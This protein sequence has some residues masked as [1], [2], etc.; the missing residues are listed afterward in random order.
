MINYI[1]KGIART[2]NIS[3]SDVEAGKYGPLLKFTKYIGAGFSSSSR[4]IIRLLEINANSIRTSEIYITTG[5]NYNTPSAP[6][7]NCINLIPSEVGY[8]LNEFE[9]HYIL[10]VRPSKLGGYIS[11]Q[12]LFCENI[13]FIESYNFEPFIVEHDSLDNVVE[14]VN[15]YFTLTPSGPRGIKKTGTS[16]GYYKIATLFARWNTL[17]CTYAFSIC[18]TQN[19]DIGSFIGGTVYIKAR[20]TNDDYLTVTIKTGG[21]TENFTNDKINIIAVPVS[22]DK[23]EIYIHSLKD[24]NA[25]QIKDDFWEYDNNATYV[26]VFE[27]IFYETISTDN[28]TTLF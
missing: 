11:A 9:D 27:P 26:R 14:P 28:Q 1:P 6:I 12:V 24:W 7:V 4:F 17:G 13:S 22:S 16:K 2:K 18:N 3:A 15:G 5:E 23:V 8:I 10:Y 20:H 25:V 21:T 19:G